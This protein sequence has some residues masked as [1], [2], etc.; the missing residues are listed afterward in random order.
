MPEIKLLAELGQAASLRL[1]VERDAETYPAPA[2]VKRLM[3]LLSDWGYPELAVRLAKG[4]S[5]AGLYQPAFTHPLIAL[6]AYPGPGA[7]P[8]PV[9]VLGLIRQETEFDAYAVSSAGARGLMQLMLTSAKIAARQ[10]HLPYRPDALLGD[11]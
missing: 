10:A 6:P 5:Y 9:L 1:F 7:A 3:L 4:L 8:D 2:H 11:T